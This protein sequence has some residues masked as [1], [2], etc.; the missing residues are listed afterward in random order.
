L[1]RPRDD[2]SLLGHSTEPSLARPQI[3]KAIFS[4]GCSPQARA[5]PTAGSDRGSLRSHDLTLFVRPAEEVSSLDFYTV[6]ADI[7][8][9]QQQVVDRP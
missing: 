8:R 4:T 5:R 2:R 1:P 9:D 6:I 7:Q 3:P